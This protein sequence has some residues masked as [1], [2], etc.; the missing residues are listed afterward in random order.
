MSLSTLFVIFSA[1]TF[2]ITHPI[3]YAVT[4]FKPSIFAPSIPTF[5]GEVRRSTQSKLDVGVVRPQNRCRAS[6]QRA[7]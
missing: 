3:S 6:E 5:V 1:Y 4:R 2:P 7:D